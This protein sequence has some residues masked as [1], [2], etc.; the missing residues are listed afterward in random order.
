MIRCRVGSFFPWVACNFL[1]NFLLASPTNVPTD[2]IVRI[3]GGNSSEWRMIRCISLY[4]SS[5][6]S[7][8]YRGRNGTREDMTRRYGHLS[9]L[10]D[11]G[12]RRQ[13]A[14][15]AYVHARE[16]TCTCV[17]AGGRLR[18]WQ[19]RRA[20]PV[21]NYP[22]ARSSFLPVPQ[23]QRFCTTSRSLRTR[24][25][26]YANLETGSPGIFLRAVGYACALDPFAPRKSLAERLDDV[27]LKEG[28][29]TRRKRKRKLLSTW[30]ICIVV[31]HGWVLSY[32]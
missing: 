17:V 5:C 12:T 11:R 19:A 18:L 29:S 10:L 30:C 15:R 13:E 20:A 26:S 6:L 25:E 28:R 32:V 14:W 2:A 21:R 24:R 1:S 9:G 16:R 8:V 22:E 31:R 3:S 4:L 23:V 7:R 27:V